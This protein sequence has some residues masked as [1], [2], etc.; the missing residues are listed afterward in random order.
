MHKATRNN[1]KAAAHG[2]QP[3]LPNIVRLAY[4][5]PTGP[6]PQTHAPE[7]FD[8]LGVISLEDL[9]ESLGRS[10]K[11]IRNWVARREIPF[12]SIHGRTMF[13][14]QSIV[15]WLAAQEVRP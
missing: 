1:L 2:P 7:L 8:N 5:D 15:S 14:R 4:K 12:L 13:L 11:T 6:R 10:P 3:P 9:A